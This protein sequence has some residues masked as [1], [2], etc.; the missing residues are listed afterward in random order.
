MFVQGCEY[1]DAKLMPGL[2]AEYP[3]PP[4]VTISKLM[5]TRQRTEVQLEWVTQGSGN[6]TGFM[7]QRRDT[8][9]TFSNSS[10]SVDSL[11]ET[12]A[13]DI[14]PDI[15]D[16]RLGGLDPAMVYAFRILAVNHRTTGHPSEMKTPGEV[17]RAVLGPWTFCQGP[18]CSP[19]PQP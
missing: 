12:V 17:T 1:L 16:H 14:E 6:L 7:V 15:R 9:R 18:Y 5:Y 8:K 10:R 19:D 13:S 4:N 2:P 11:W 3:V